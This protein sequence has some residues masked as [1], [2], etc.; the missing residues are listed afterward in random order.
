MSGTRPPSYADKRSTNVPVA[1]RATSRPRMSAADGAGAGGG[2]P[3]AGASANSSFRSSD[4]RAEYA[5]RRQQQQQQQQQASGGGYGSTTASASAAHK[6]ST[7]TNAR[8][9]GRLV[10]ERRTE[11]VQ[12]TTRET[13]V[14]RTKSP[15]RRSAAPSEKSR[16][17]YE[18]LRPQQPVEPRP[19]EQRTEMPP[20]GMYPAPQPIFHL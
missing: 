1:D 17:S 4:A 9:T 13:L 12:V 15:E 19:R 20:S 10:D 3:G 5:A 16:G 8:A 7:S 14:T 11:R 2:T 18:R 6:R